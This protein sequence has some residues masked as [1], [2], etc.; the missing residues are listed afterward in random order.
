MCCLLACRRTSPRRATAVT[1]QNE[2]HDAIVGA[3]PTDPGELLPGTLDEVAFY[4]RAL[5][6]DEVAAHRAAGIH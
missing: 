3:G 2:T 1:A 5:S 4:S 6:M